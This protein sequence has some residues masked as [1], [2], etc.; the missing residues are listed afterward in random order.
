MAAGAGAGPAGREA[1][2]LMGLP[3]DY[4]LPPRYNDAYHL[5]GG[6]PAAR[7]LSEALLTPL[8]AAADAV[9]LAAVQ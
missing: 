4:R 5:A 7:F 6:V 9:A 3:E 2:R 8:L 1:A